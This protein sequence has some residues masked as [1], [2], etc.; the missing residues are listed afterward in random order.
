MPVPPI[1]APAP[2]GPKTASPQQLAALAGA[3]TMG[4]TALTEQNF[5]EADKFIAQAAELALADEHQQMVARLREVGGYVKQ[6]RSAVEAGAKRLE[7]RE[8]PVGTSAIVSFVE[9]LPDRVIVRTA[10]QNRN[11]PYAELPPGLAQAIVDQQ[12][13]GSDPTSRVVKG[14]YYAV[15]RGDRKTLVEK[16]QTWWEEAQL[17]GV[18]TSHLMPFLTDDYESLKSAAAGNASAATVPANEPAGE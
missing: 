16:A 7:T 10:G 8:L 17:G 18:D 9:V 5:D 3:L 6:F 14:A 4:R 15:A 1:T 2:E 13:D 12:L 11:Y